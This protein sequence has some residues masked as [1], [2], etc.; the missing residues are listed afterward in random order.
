MNENESVVGFLS[1]YLSGLNHWRGM[2]PIPEAILSP[3]VP[4]KPFS[5]LHTE[6]IPFSIAPAAFSKW[7]FKIE[8]AT[9]FLYIHRLSLL[10]SIF[11]LHFKH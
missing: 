10:F 5:T 11:S 9:G 8:N 6:K 2:A 7:F 1:A 4:S 3:T